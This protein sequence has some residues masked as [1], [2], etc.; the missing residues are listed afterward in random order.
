ERWD[1][2]GRGQTRQLD[3]SAFKSDPNRPP[4]EPSQILEPLEAA[5]RAL[6]GAETPWHVVCVP[7]PRPANPL[8]IDTSWAEFFRG[9]FHRVVYLT[10]PRR[11]LRPPRRVLAL[12]RP[13]AWDP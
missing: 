11:R 5:C 1:D 8:S 6:A 2:R 12:L 9:A 13:G 4:D 10:R 7:P 3:K